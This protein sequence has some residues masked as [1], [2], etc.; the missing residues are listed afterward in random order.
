MLYE[1]L[2]HPGLGVQRRDDDQLQTEPLEQPQGVLRKPVVNFRKHLVDD[3][4]PE[5]AVRVALSGQVEVVLIGDRGDQNCERQAG[6]L[7]AGLAAAVLVIAP[8][9]AGVVFD[10]TR[11]EIVPTADVDHAVPPRRLFA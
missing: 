11:A 3:D 4:E 9:S 1:R 8:P 7:A 6:F 5:S 10:L 2:G